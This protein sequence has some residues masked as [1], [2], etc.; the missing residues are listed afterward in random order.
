MIVHALKRHDTYIHLFSF[1][2][3]KSYQIYK[4]FQLAPYSIAF[5]YTNLIFLS[6]KI[7]YY[8]WYYIVLF[9]LLNEAFFILLF[10]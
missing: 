8:D 9:F 4:D 1:W 2:S 3:S 10:E 6:H 7:P 5:V